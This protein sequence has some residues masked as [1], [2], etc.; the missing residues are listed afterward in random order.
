[1]TKIKM[2]GLRRKEDIEAVNELRPDYVGF[3]FFPG[4]KRYITPETAK[5]LKA[6]L[7]PGIRTVGV[8]VDEKPENVA[9]KVTDRAQKDMTQKAGRRKKPDHDGR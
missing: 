6:G 4:S 5:E 7:A 2:C 1:M 8:F 9:D 3:V